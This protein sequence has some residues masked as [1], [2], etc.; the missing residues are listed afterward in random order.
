[1][2][3]FITNFNPIVSAEA[4]SEEFHARYSVTGKRYIY[5][6]AT[7]PVQSPFLRQYELHH[8]FKTDVIASTFGSSD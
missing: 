1:M 8:P 5:K 7:A 2:N 3:S 6:V 4:V